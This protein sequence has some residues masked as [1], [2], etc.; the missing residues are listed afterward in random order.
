M[1]QIKNYRLPFK[2]IL[3]IDFDLTICLSEYPK[4]GAERPGS[5]KNLKKLVGEGYGI[6]INTCREGMA[7]AGAIEWLDYNE[8][9]YHYINCN[10][11]HVISEYGADCRKVSADLYVDDKCLMGLPDWDTIYKIID[12]RF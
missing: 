6:I 11:P 1:G 8:V 3:A 2:A 4:L 9:P 7:L 12:S 10:F 5:V